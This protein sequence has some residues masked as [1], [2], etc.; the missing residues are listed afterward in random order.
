[1]LALF[2]FQWLN[3]QEGKQQL[4]QSTIGTS[5]R[6]LTIENLKKVKLFIPNNELIES[7]Y[8][9]IYAMIKKK[10]TLYSENRNLAVQRDMLIPRLMSGKLEV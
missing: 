5:Q 9:R 7:Y 2:L 6:A 8:H 10:R 1:M 4:L 3:L